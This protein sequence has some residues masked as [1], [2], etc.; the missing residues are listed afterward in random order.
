MDYMSL[1]HFA[2]DD[3]SKRPFPDCWWKGKDYSLEATIHESIAELETRHALLGFFGCLDRQ[4]RVGES[5]A[6][7]YIA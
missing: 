2:P 6:M 7:Q 3:N 1:F 4:R 5:I